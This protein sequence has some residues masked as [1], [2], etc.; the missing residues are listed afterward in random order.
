MVVALHS[1]GSLVMWGLGALSYGPPVANLSVTS[2]AI[3][4]SSS[5]FRTVAGAVQCWGP[6][7]IP[8]HLRETFAGVSSDGLAQVASVA[9]CSALGAMWATP[10]HLQRD[11]RLGAEWCAWG[12]V[13]NSTA[14]EVVIPYGWFVS[15]ADA[16]PSA[17]MYP[18][19]RPNISGCSDSGAPRLYEAP[20]NDRAV[21]HVCFGKKPRPEDVPLGTKILPFNTA[22]WSLYDIKGNW[23]SLD[24]CGLW[25]TFCL[26]DHAAITSTQQLGSADAGGKQQGRQSATACLPCTVPQQSLL[27]VPVVAC[28]RC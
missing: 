5:C 23:D 17:L 20:L 25:C 12:Y 1:N 4:G 6:E 11:W 7:M 15:R 16:V 26:V 28:S 21:A 24:E 27:L 18:M 3:S 8:G 14:N 10:G 2:M 13:T 9:V 22:Q 19:Q